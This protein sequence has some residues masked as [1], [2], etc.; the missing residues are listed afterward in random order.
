MSES[1]VNARREQSLGEEIANS[2]SHSVGLVG[3]VVGTPFLLVAAVDHGDLAFLVGAWV[4]CVAMLVLYS[5]ST[6]YHVLPRGP[7]KRLFRVLDHSAIFLLIAG[8][9]TPFTVGVLRDSVG[10]PLFA[11]VWALAIVGV[12]MK[13]VSSA[14]HPIAS[15]TL[16]LAM[17]WVVLLVAD[18]LVAAVPLPGLAWLLA[19][20]LSYSLGLVFFAMDAR[21]R[22]GHTV[23]HVFVVAGTACHYFAVLWYAA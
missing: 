11:T 15:T 6:V 2:I 13:A 5:A 20:G 8:T 1:Q 17:G 22:Y 7:I 18:A 3:A 14:E 23:W 10:W 4:F 21:L 9:Y 19:G 16:Y 12:A